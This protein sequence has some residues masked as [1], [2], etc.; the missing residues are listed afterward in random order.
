MRTSERLRVL[1]ERLKERGNACRARVPGLSALLRS[2][3]LELHV[4]IDR[5]ATLETA[6]E[7]MTEPAE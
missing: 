5:V 6:F 1:A 4:L 3:A 7:E 2:D